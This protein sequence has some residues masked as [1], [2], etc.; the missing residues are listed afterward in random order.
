MRAVTLPKFWHAWSFW[1]T[2]S[3]RSPSKPH[4]G[5]CPLTRPACSS[6]AYLLIMR[7]CLIGYRL[8]EQPRRSYF[9]PRGYNGLSRKVSRLPCSKDC[10]TTRFFGCVPMLLQQHPDDPQPRGLQIF[11]SFLT[12]K[13]RWYVF[14]LNFTLVPSPVPCSA[15]GPAFPSIIF[16]TR[17]SRRTRRSRARL[18]CALHVTVC[19]RT[20]ASAHRGLSSRGLESLVVVLI[21]PDKNER[22]AD[23]VVRGISISISPSRARK[24]PQPRHQLPQHWRAKVRART[25]FRL[26]DAS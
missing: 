5:R 15:S 25:A 8:E 7:G 3:R 26:V 24:S 14:R 10:L 11:F 23:D 13:A 17:S 9:W 6:L 22:A 12:Q 1:L 16:S 19:G 21:E 20:S 4:H 2:W 18:G